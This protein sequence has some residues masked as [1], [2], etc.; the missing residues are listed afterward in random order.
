MNNQMGFILI[1]KEDGQLESVIKDDLKI[2][3]R[4]QV[5]SFY[6]LFDIEQQSKGRELLEAAYFRNNILRKE[7]TLKANKNFPS[8]FLMSLP[9]GNKIAICGA[10]TSLNLELYFD[11]LIKDLNQEFIDLKELF[12]NE[13]VLSKKVAE[14]NEGKDFVAI[15]QEAD[16]VKELQ[17]KLE[18]KNNELRNKNKELDQ[19]AHIISH[20]LKA[21]LS[22]SK[23]IVHLLK[24]KMEKE[25]TDSEVLQ[26][27][28][29]L[30][31]S[32]SHMSNLIDTINAYSISGML[33]NEVT[34]FP[35]A[36]LYEEIL[37]NLKAPAQMYFHL[38]DR[39]PQIIANRAQLYQILLNLV[40]NAIRFHHM[41]EG[42]IV[43]TFTEDQH[44]YHFGVRDDGPGIPEEYHG[45]IFEIFNKVH[46]RTFNEGTGVGLSIVK[47]LVENAGGILSLESKVG[48]GSDFR[49]SWPKQKLSE[50]ADGS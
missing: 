26:L 12:I 32:T 47:K 46:R 33:D 24:K 31:L 7:F 30:M 2:F 48:K 18:Q 1:C 16:I 35:L 4:T 25:K 11:E 29:M 9:F 36:D 5:N 44:E 49:F 45:K 28:D 10:S 22:Q 23:L 43:L 40:S 17:R 37:Q 19:F 15:E 14:E 42:N 20:D 38:P 41:A 6:D 50:K 27:F 3:E 8:L 13:N 21:P 34:S 39:L